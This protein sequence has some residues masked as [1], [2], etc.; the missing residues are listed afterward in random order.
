MISREMLYAMRMQMK[1]QPFW[2]AEKFQKIPKMSWK[3]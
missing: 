3:A 2:A 1:R